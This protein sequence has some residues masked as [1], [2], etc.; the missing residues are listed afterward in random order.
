MYIIQYHNI[1]Q[2]LYICVCVVVFDQ[3]VWKLHG[4][5]PEHLVAL[6][7]HLNRDVKRPESCNSD[8]GDGPW[9]GTRKVVT[10]SGLWM[11]YEFV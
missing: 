8:S 11:A 6:P 10:V 7:R 9:G 3:Y 4:Q 2:L 5:Q 1:I